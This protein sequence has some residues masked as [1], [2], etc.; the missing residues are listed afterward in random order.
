MKTIRI[1]QTI[2]LQENSTLQ[3]DKFA[4]NHLLKVL[5]LKNQ[6][7]F[8]LFNGDGYEYP[9]VLE[10]SGKTAIA[11]I[12]ARQHTE[13]ESAL[14]IHLFQGI[15][16]GDRMDFAIQKSVELGATEITPVFCERTVVNLKGERLQKKIEHWQSIVH[17][18]CEQ[19]GR[20]FIPVIHSAVHS[21]HLF[22][23]TTDCTRLILDPTAVHSLKQID[24][25]V[26]NQLKLLI[27][28]EGGLSKH[29]IQLALDSGFINTRLGPRVLR[30]ETAALTTIAA[31]QVLWGDL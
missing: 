26:N 23:A 6:Q 11:H 8:I 2:N 28:P 20:N 29:E 7:A 17:S 14:K 24:P 4:S 10:V 31:A 9:S 1:F 21:S 12:S 13:N 25:P 18:A 30:T 3:L 27:G 16:K 15:S 19:C 22:T 5:R